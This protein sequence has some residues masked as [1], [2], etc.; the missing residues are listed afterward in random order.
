MLRL[1]PE[2]DRMFTSRQTI[3]SNT[4]Q[5]EVIS[6]FGL[7][8]KQVLR[9]RSVRPPTLFSSF[10]IASV[11]RPL[12]FHIYFRMSFHMFAKMLWVFDMDILNQYIV[13]SSSVILTRLHL[14]INEY[15]MSFQLFRNL[16]N[17]ISFGNILYFSVQL[18][19]LNLFL[20]NLFL[21]LLQVEQ[22]S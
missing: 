2:L 10:K 6:M 21:M 8:L 9:S 20:S 4:A 3:L 11:F 5:K 14:P 17:L 15:G 18:P 13:Q 12:R 16:K 1:W 19:W 7:T 22:F